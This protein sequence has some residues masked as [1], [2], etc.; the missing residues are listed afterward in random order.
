MDGFVTAYSK[1]TGQKQ[2]VPEHFI[3]HPVLGPNLTLTPQVR[4]GLRYPEGTPTAAWKATQLEA[5]ADDHDVDLTGARTKDDM[6]AAIATA[7]NPQNADGTPSSD[8]TPA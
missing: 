5:Y 8:E 6:V 7:A 4:D 1:L 2:R 3:G